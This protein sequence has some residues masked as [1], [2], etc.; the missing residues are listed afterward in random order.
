VSV[1]VGVYPR[2][3]NAD[4]LQADNVFYHLTYEGNIDIEVRSAPYPF[5]CYYLAPASCF[6]IL[7]HLSLF[8]SFNRSLYLF[9]LR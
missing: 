1:P 8:P 2:S 9:L 3:H 7:P 6:H 5:S 4:D